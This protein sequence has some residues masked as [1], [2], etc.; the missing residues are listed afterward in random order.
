MKHSFSI[1]E[2]KVVSPRYF[3]SCLSRNKSHVNYNDDY[4]RFSTAHDLTMQN[5]YF[6]R[7]EW[8]IPDGVRLVRNVNIGH[9]ELHLDEVAYS[10]CL[11]PCASF[12]SAMIVCR[13][14]VS[15]NVLERINSP[16]PISYPNNPTRRLLRNSKNFW[17]RYRIRITSGEI[18]KHHVVL[19]ELLKVANLGAILNCLPLK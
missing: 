18:A 4:F 6:S 9:G 7:S 13:R 11:E 15:R 5:R 14:R 1:S 10:V 2:Q 17:V 16:C 19:S 3:S 12:S 8:F